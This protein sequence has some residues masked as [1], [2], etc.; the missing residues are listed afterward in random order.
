MMKD[1]HFTHLPFELAADASFSDKAVIWSVF[2]E[3][4]APDRYN[5]YKRELLAQY[6]NL[7][8]VAAKH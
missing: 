5:A 4:N 8:D 6:G 7:R 2:L 1:L 3:K